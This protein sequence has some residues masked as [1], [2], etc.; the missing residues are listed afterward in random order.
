MHGIGFGITWW[1]V[2]RINSKDPGHRSTASTN[3]ER[4]SGTPSTPRLPNSLTMKNFLKDA[5][6]CTECGSGAGAT[7]CRADLKSYNIYIYINNYIH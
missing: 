2:Q 4:L 7:I 5:D 1:V 3:H 6:A